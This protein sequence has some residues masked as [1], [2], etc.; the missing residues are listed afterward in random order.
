MDSGL[1]NGAAYCNNNGEVEMVD[2]T[3]KLGLPYEAKN[4]SH[5][6]QHV[7]HVP[8]TSDLANFNLGGPYTAS[9]VEFF[10]LV[11][12]SSGRILYA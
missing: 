1:F 2:L 7:N 11:Y 12:N 9:Q 3:L 4:A 6:R 5:L 8:A 10:F